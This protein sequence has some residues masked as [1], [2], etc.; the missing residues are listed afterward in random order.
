MKELKIEDVIIIY[1][2]VM[3]FVVS[4][5]DSK[6]GKVV[7]LDSSYYYDSILCIF[8]SSRG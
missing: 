6:D 4:F 1:C 2:D 7:F 3:M 5:R 8:I